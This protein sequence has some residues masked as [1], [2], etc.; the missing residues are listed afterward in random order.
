M[1]RLSSGMNTPQNIKLMADM[2]KETANAM[3]AFIEKVAGLYDLAG[4]VLFGS[5]LKTF[6]SDSDADVARLLQGR[7]G[8]FVSTKPVMDDLAY[9]VPFGNGHPHS[10]A[11][12]P[13]RRM[14]S[15]RSVFQSAPASQHRLRMNL[16]MK[17]QELLEEATRAVSS[18]GLLLTLGTP[19]ARVIAP[20]TPCL[21]RLEQ[22]CWHPWRRTAPR[23][24]KRIVG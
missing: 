6:R 9:D 23:L 24:P 14:E 22:L 2:G 3:R 10:A 8:K 18:A 1:K 19:M 13:G 5:A 20:I 17:V 16:G 4:A 11:S 7:P 15:S 12:F 21:M